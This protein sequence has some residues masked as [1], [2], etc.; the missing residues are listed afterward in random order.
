MTNTTN[1][2]PAPEAEAEA[3]AEAEANGRI[4]NRLDSPRFHAETRLIVG[5]GRKANLSAVLTLKAVDVLRGE[6]SRIAAEALDNATL[7]AAKANKNGE[8]KVTATGKTVTARSVATDATAICRWSE[9]FA[10]RTG[11]DSILLESAVLAG[12][13]AADLLG[14]MKR[15]DNPRN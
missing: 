4:D 2:T 13:K 3:K 12:T 11:A 6:L 5:I 14:W 10:K 7:K 8:V 1:T 9:E 15:L